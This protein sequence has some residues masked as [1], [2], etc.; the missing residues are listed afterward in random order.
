[1]KK[2]NCQNLVVCALTEAEDNI[3]PFQVDPPSPHH[4]KTSGFWYF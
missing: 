1:M 2:I 4:L 3:N